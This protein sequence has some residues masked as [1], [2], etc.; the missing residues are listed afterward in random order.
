LFGVEASPVG[1]G[2]GDSLLYDEAARYADDLSSL[3]V[4]EML[5]GSAFRASNL[6]FDLEGVWRGS[7]IRYG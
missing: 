2:I 5:T 3:V 4:L 6:V 7:R 1:T